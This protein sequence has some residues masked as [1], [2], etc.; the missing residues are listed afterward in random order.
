MYGA[1]DI[2]ACARGATTNAYERARL[3]PR[4]SS[5][6]KLK[7]FGQ[8][9]GG[10]RADEDMQNACRK[11]WR[12]RWR[13]AIARAVRPARSAGMVFQSDQAEVRKRYLDKEE[14]CTQ[15]PKKLEEPRQLLRIPWLVTC[16]ELVGSRA[17]RIAKCGS[18]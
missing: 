17:E 11:G 16:S 1:R 4:R 5:G 3:H 7:V 12:P 14:L 8:T 10:N 6:V 2:A 18:H 15:I 13:N 9:V